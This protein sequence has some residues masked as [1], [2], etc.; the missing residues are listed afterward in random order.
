MRGILG[1]KVAA[2]LKVSKEGFEFA[3]NFLPEKLEKPA[4]KIK[5]KH[6]KALEAR[7]IQKKKFFWAANQKSDRNGFYQMCVLPA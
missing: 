1:G 5:T 6:H 4:Q 2:D 7:V 3:V